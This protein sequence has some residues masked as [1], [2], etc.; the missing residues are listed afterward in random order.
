MII[1]AV[2]LFSIQ[3]NLDKIVLQVAV[4]FLTKLS[5]QY[6][7]HLLIILVIVSIK[8]KTFAVRNQNDK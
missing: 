2:K 3:M 7:V 6:P 1:V 5:I 8:A 4:N